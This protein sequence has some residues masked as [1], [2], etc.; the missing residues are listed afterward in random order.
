VNRFALATLAKSLEWTAA[1]IVTLNE[2]LRLPPSA[3][4]TPADLER[5]AAALT[6]SPAV[7]FERLSNEKKITICAGAIVRTPDGI[8]TVTWVNEDCTRW[9]VEF[10]PNSD[11]PFTGCT[12]P[13]DQLDLLN[14]TNHR[15]LEVA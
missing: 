15:A 11:L 13:L 2:C 14:D 9:L 4:R 3:E 5:I 1:D 10:D 6:G 12:Y 8:G 7:V